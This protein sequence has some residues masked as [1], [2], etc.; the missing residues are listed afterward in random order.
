[1]KKE[2]RTAA[3]TLA[4]VAALGAASG[5]A[6]QA[7]TTKIGYNTT[8]G[9]FNGN[10]YSG[11]GKKAYADRAV[12]LWSDNV[13]GNYGV[14]ARP[15]HSTGNG[16]WQR[17]NDFSY[18]SW[19]NSYNRGDDIRIQFSNDATTPVAVQVNGVWRSN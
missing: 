1:M 6:A 10:G 2:I 14:D 3:A 7:S 15:I 16:N 4:C 5:I 8:V 13:G 19:S 11:Y 17:V 18:R 12:E 9:R